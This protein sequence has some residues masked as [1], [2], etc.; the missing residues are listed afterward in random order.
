MQYQI[1][2]LDDLNTI[3]RMKHAIAGS[4]E[5]AFGLVVEK[6]WPRGALTAHVIDSYGHLTVFKP[7]VNSRSAASDRA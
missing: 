1:E 2:F 3:V 4:P 6:G 5:I 7:Q